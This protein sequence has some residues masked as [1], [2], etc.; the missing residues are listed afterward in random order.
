[1]PNKPLDQAAL[2]ALLQPKS[3]KK[4]KPPQKRFPA[5][6]Q[7]GP[8][9]YYENEMRCVVA[10]YYNYEDGNKVW[11]KT[12][13]CHASTHYKFLGKPVCSTHA[14][15]EMNE[16]LI[17]VEMNIGYELKVN[18][19]GECNHLPCNWSPDKVDPQFR[20]LLKNAN[21]LNTEQT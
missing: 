15:R 20:H 14:L 5:P 18:E 13:G 2:A 4:E 11:V 8:L 10:G 21:S 16:L 12:Q 17:A 3:Q 9:R 19:D 6:P 1:V 7:E